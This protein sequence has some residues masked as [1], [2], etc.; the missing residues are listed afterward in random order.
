MVDIKFNEYSCDIKVVDEMGTINI[1]DL[2]PFYEKIEVDK[3]A[4]RYTEKKL[5][6]TLKKWLDT[7]WLTLVKEGATSTKDKK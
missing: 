1:L 5:S 3:S 6:I 7:K 2:A 4:W